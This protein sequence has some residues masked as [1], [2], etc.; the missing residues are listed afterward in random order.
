MGI[1]SRQSPKLNDKTISYEKIHNQA[2][3]QMY[4]K[5]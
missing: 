2:M 1:V 5:Y 4:T 3:V